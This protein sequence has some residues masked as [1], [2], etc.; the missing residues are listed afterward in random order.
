MGARCFL[1]RSVRIAE[2]LSDFVSLFF[3]VRDGGCGGVP[4]DVFPP[5]VG[6]GTRGAFRDKGEGGAA[7]PR[8]ECSRRNSLLGGGFG[9]GTGTEFPP[10]LAVAMGSY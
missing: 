5:R 6:V 8:A 1:G 3:V 7:G 4:R 10:V 2:A 9:D